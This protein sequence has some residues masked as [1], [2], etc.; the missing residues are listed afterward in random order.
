MPRVAWDHETVGSTP[1][2]PT[3][4]LG[5]VTAARRSDMAAAVVQLH[6][7][8]LE[9]AETWGRGDTEMMMHGRIKRRHDN[10]GGRG[11]TAAQQTFNLVGEGSNP[12]GPM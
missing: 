5:G 4:S 11:V 7:G 8:R 2:I 3:F 6:P 10:L 9:D 12:S 1:T